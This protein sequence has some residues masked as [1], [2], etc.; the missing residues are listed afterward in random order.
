MYATRMKFVPT[1]ALPPI[2]LCSSTSHHRCRYSEFKH[3]L[4]EIRCINSGRV[5]Y[6]ANALRFYSE[7]A[8]HRGIHAWD[9]S[10]LSDSIDVPFFILVVTSKF[11]ASDLRVSAPF[12]IAGGVAGSESCFAGNTGMPRMC[13]LAVLG[14]SRNGHLVSFPTHSV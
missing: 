9:A 4:I 3:R 10:M 11:A 8:P 2:K 7:F 5:K 14:F 1:S 13:T 12:K 6:I